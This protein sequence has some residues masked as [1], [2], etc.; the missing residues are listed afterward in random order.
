MQGYL[1]CVCAA[2]VNERDLLCKDARPR[3]LKCA[4]CHI[5]GELIRAPCSFEPLL[6][7]LRLLTNMTLKSN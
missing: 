4:L 7:D 5:L 1:F 2:S 6:D 3:D